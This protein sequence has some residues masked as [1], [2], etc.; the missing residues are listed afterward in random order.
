MPKI[1]LPTEYINNCNV[2]YNDYIRSYTNNNRTEWVDIYFKNNY[3]LKSGNTSY[4]TNV[5]CD[6]LNTYTDDFYYR[7]DL[8]N[9]LIIFWF[10]CVFCFLLPLRILTRLFRRFWP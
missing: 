9:S 1:Y 5:V 10:L 4:P 2:V 3:I 6:T 8:C 7:Y